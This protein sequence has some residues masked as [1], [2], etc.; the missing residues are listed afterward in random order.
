MDVP[1]V[2]FLAICAA[3]TA[4]VG[5]YFVLGIR[6]GS[7]P[8]VE[9][10]VTSARVE[11]VRVAT[12]TGSKSSQVFRISYSFS[13][14]GRDYSGDRVSMAPKGWYSNTSTSL[15][16]RYSTGQSVTVRYDPA[17]PSV[18][19]LISGVLHNWSLYAIGGMFAIFVVLGLVG[20]IRSQS[21]SR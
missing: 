20:L 5:R 12:S 18:C 21:N 6:S 2:I 8:S 7:W 1:S 11:K 10:T 9:G 14:N 4:Y 15:H 19:T 13:V 3:I 17:N 16:K